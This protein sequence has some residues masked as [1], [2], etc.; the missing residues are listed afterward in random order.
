MMTMMRRRRGRERG[1]NHCGFRWAFPRQGKGS[2]GIRIVSMYDHQYCGERR[3]Q[4][5][6]V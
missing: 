5:R 1:I 4:I 3:R 6:T 2:K